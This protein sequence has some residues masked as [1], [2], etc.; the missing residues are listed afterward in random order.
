MGGGKDLESASRPTF[1]EIE[2]L[3]LAVFSF[4]SSLPSGYAAG[5]DRPGIAPIR[6]YS[7]F[8]V[9]NMTLDEQPGIPPWVETT[10]NQNDLEYACKRVAA[11]REEADFFIVNMHWGIP[12]GSCVTFQ[13]PLADYQLPLA[14]ALIDA[15]ADLILGH[16]PHVIHG[17]EKYKHGLIAYSLGNFLFHS[18]DQDQELKLT[19]DYPPYKFDSLTQGKHEKQ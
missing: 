19:V 12:N 13:G 11:A 2:G 5:P 17:V 1:V 14:H 7:K 9:D 15:G 3:R 8:F 10:V 4:T 16:H 6:A 18:F